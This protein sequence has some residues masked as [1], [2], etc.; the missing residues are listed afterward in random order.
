MRLMQEL[1]ELWGD[2]PPVDLLLFEATDPE[3]PPKYRDYFARSLRN[4]GKM[5]P[6]EARS[7]LAA[8]MREAMAA[9]PAGRSRPERSRR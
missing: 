4:V 3:A 5:S 8:R 2:A 7:E 6:S 9:S 1:R